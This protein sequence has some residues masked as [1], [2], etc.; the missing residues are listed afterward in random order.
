VEENKVGSY[1]VFYSVSEED[2]VRIRELAKD[3]L[4]KRGMGNAKPGNWF[5]AMKQIEDIVTI[6]LRGKG[7]YHEQRTENS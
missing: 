4:D 1:K 3:R 7:D 2:L 5:I 6:I